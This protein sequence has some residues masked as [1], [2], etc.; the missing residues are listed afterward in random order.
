MLSRELGVALDQLVN[1]S[2]AQVRPLAAE[3][4]LTLTGDVAAVH[5]WGDAAALA[6]VVNNLLTHEPTWRQDQDLFGT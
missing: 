3:R 6:Q 4:N 5:V 1:D 2:L